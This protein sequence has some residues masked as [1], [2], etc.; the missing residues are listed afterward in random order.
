MGTQAGSS[1]KVKATVA[2]RF[3]CGVGF[4]RI[5]FTATDDKGNSSNC[6]Q[7]I[8]I[9]DNTPISVT[10]P[11]D[12]TVVCTTV[13][14]GGYQGSLDPDDLPGNNTP[15]INGDD[16]ELIAINYEDQVFTISDSACFKV[17]RTWTVINWCIFDA[18]GPNTVANGFYSDVQEIKVVDQ[19]AP[20]LDCPD[21]FTVGIFNDNCNATVNIP[22]PDADDCAP[23]E[24]LEYSVSGDFTLGST[25]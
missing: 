8:N 24:L 10:F 3:P 21:D 18:D 19:A 16:C 22:V 17:L 23:D 4:V 1:P 2:D 5:R 7:R 20:V 9:V 25:W 11:P 15:N 12:R 6:V 14:G 13:G